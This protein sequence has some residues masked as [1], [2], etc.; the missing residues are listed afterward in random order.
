MGVMTDKKYIIISDFNLQSN[1]RGTAALGYGSIL[2]LLK[3]GYIN[4]EFEIIKYRFYRNPF[5][6][7]KKEGVDE[8]VINGTRWKQHVFNVFFIEKYLYKYHLH[9]F[10]TSFNKTIK[11]VKFVA[12]LNGGDGLT[13]IYGET[14]LNT[15]LPEINFAIEFKIP[16]I[17]MPQ[18]IGPFLQE[19]NKERIIAILRKAKQIYVRDNNFNEDLDK[20]GISYTK[21]KDLSF[22]MQP[23]PFS[24]DIQKPCVG[25]NISGLAYSNK[26]GNLAGEFDLYPLLMKRIV[27]LF[28]SKGCKIYLIPH[29]YNVNSPEKNNDDMEATEHF[30]NRIENKT[31][32]YFV[33]KNLISPQLKFLIS[34][35]DFF[36]GT[37]M[38]ANF[39]A[40]FTGTPVFGL[41]YSYKFK[42]AFENNGIHNRTADI[43]NVNNE[44]IEEIVDLIDAAYQEDVN[45]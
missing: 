45:K 16:F 25:I 20:N 29:S 23:I 30:Y 37:R 17:I 42:S 3:K 40:I 34:Q 32:V 41:A 36:V 44:Q 11:N 1:N 43:N 38:H 14:L 6:K 39:A 9:I 2:F 8:F 21:T 26:F 12:A 24:I 10:Q 7:L 15:R 18:T 19:K 35:M 4:R 28:L 13:D 33:N 5:R 22:F 27:E 31:N